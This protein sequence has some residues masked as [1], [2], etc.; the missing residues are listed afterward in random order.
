[1]GGDLSFQL[2]G[3][4]ALPLG[5]EAGFGTPRFRFSFGVRYAPLGRDSDGDG[6]EDKFDF[7]PTTF[8]VS[9]AGATRMGCPRVPPHVDPHVEL[10]IEPSEFEHPSSVGA[11]A[12]AVPAK[13]YRESTPH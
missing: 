1:M 2:G 11:P 4:G 3:G 12:N 7:C 10:G 8:A 5:S 6:V 9:E 13:H